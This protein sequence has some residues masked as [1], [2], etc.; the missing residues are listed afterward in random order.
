MILLIGGC[1]KR[2]APPRVVYTPAPPAA[3]APAKTEAPETMVIAEPA[4][5]EEPVQGQNTSPETP[6]PDRGG[7]PARRRHPITSGQTPA[8]DNAEPETS[9]PAP[10]V[11]LPALEPRESPQKEVALRAQIQAI[12]ENVRGRLARINEGRLSPDDRKTLD[13]ARSFF[14]QST[15]ALEE[16]DL[17]RALNLAQKASQLVTALEK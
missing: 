8:D 13:D 14:A 10:D 7:G 15:R 17:Q 6:S 4:A 16:S 9:E 12:Q 3:A 5:P 1:P 11:A 2:Q